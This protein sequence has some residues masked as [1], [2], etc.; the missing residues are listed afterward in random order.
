MIVNEQIPGAGIS[1]GALETCG[2][3]KIAILEASD[4]EVAGE[5]GVEMGHFGR[6]TVK[7]AGLGMFFAGI[8][9]EVALSCGVR[10]FVGAGG[11]SRI[12]G[13]ALFGGRFG[14]FRHTTP[15]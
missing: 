13:E 11:V 4:L 1:D 9:G 5:F 7:L 6:T 8:P 10:G 2:E 14:E 15:I 12:G 3:A